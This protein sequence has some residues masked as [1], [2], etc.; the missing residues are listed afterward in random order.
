[1]S[2]HKLSAGD[3][4]TYLVRQVAA[5]DSTELGHDSLGDYYAAKGETPGRWVGTGLAGLNIGPAAIV[6]EA[7]MKALFGLGIHPDA[8]DIVKA[9]I[10]AGAE[11]AVAEAAT[12]LGASYRV[13][14]G[15]PQWR[16]RLAERYRAWNIVHGLPE[17]DRVPAAERERIR[18]DTALELFGEQH[19][20]A[21]LHDGELSGFLARQ[22][23]LESA[24]VA[25][26]DLT[27][28][29][30]KSV[31]SLWAVA[32]RAVS[33]QIEAAHD[34]AVAK[35][36]AHLEATAV[37]TR[38][39]RNGARQVDVTGLVAAQFT[40]RDSRAGDPDL[41]THVAIANKV[42]TLEG[43]WMALDARMIYRAAVTASEYYNTAL[44]AEITARIGGRFAERETAA[45]KRP[46]RELAGVDEQ[47]MRRWSTR[48]KAIEAAT[49]DLAAQFVTAHGRVPT[50]VETL[51]LAQQATLA[52]RQAKHEP[53]S[54]AEQRQVWRA[55]ALAVLGGQ[56]SLAAMLRDVHAT[57]A[58]EPVTAGLL[59]ELAAETVATVAAGRAR[60]RAANLHA[61]AIRQ[62]RA[63]G[64]DPG[65]VLEQA[66]LVAQRAMSSDHSTAIGADTDVI[67]DEQV[68][69]SLRRVDGTSQFRVAGGQLFTSPAVLAAERRILV[70]AGQAGARTLATD[71]V[72][73]AMLEWTANN[74]GRQLNPAQAQMVRDVGTTGS[75]VCLALAPAG[76][77]KTT[78][79]GVLARA[80]QASGGTVIGLA[81]QASAAEELRNALPAVDTDTVDKLVHEIKQGDPERRPEW[82]D[83]IGADSLVIV[84][85]AGLASTTNL[86]ATIDYVTGRGGRVLL[87]GDDRQRAAAG[88]GGVLR[89]IDAAYGSSSL[90][91]VMRFSDPT[92]GRATLA[93]R[94]GDP[95]AAG[96][97]TDRGRLHT[98]TSDTAVATLYS[99]W[100]SDVAA[101]RQSL[102]I[103]SSLDQVSQL[104]LLAREARLA[105][106]PPETHQG[107]E[108]TLP[109]GE[110]VSAGDTVIT[111]KNARHLSLGGSGDFVQNNHRWT[112][113]EVHPDGSLSVYLIGG[114]GRR[115][116]R[117]PASYLS[118]GHVRLGYADTLASVQGRT[119]GSAGRVDGTAHVLVDSG[120]TRN[121]LYVALSRAVT[122][123]HL[124]VQVGGGIN[125]D[126]LITPDAVHPPTAAEVFVA[127]LGRDGSARS[128]TTEIREAANP[129]AILG[130][131]AAA[132]REALVAAGEAILGPEKVTAI[133]N[134]A[135]AAV[136]GLTASPAWDTLRGHLLTIAL[137]G[138]DPVARL[139]DAAGR[140]ELDT[141]ADSGA[142]LDWRLD[143]T[144][145]HSQPAG[146]LPWLPAVPA[147]VSEHPEFS[148]YLQAWT[149]R[150]TDQAAAITA[151]AREWSPV[152]APAWA[153]PYLS[154]QDLVGT[155]ALW[156]ATAGIPDTDLRPAGPVPSRLT[157]RG[158]HRELSDACADIAGVPGEGAGRWVR[159]LAD[160]GVDVAAITSDDHW[161]VL[162]SRLNLA[163][164]ARQPVARLLEEAV[165]A[166]PLPTEAVAAALA[167]RLV[168]QLEISAQ[169]AGLD[170]QRIDPDFTDRL[171]HRGGEVHR[172][173]TDGETVAVAVLEDADRRVADLRVLQL[174]ERVISDHPAWVD[175]IVERPEQVEDELSWRRSVAAIMEYRE[176]YQV[177][178]EHSALGDPP[179]DEEQRRTYTEILRDLE[180]L[181][182]L[183]GRVETMTPVEEMEGATGSTSAV[184]HD[185]LI[186]DEIT[187]ESLAMDSA[188]VDPDGLTIDDI[189]DALEGVAA[190]RSDLARALE[191]GARRQRELDEQLSTGVGPAERKVIDAYAVLEVRAADVSQL[192]A[193]EAEVVDLRDAAVAEGVAVAGIETAIARTGRR[194]RRRLAELERA[195]AERR[196]VQARRL[197][198]LKERAGQAAA[199]QQ[200]VGPPDRQ[201]RVVEELTTAAAT[202]DERRRTAAAED[203]E[204]HAALGRSRAELAS[205]IADVE[206]QHAELLERLQ[207]LQA[208]GHVPAERE[209]QVPD[210]I[211]DEVDVASAP[212]RPIER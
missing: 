112:V 205:R 90:V 47:L 35:T 64:I 144:G 157:D 61:E 190:E 122:A 33:A 79:M 188:A 13:V 48:R 101:G 59:D 30:V 104:N 168:P 84:D 173:H 161:P 182:V 1:M 116:V 134:G 210:P 24:S 83:R 152:T 187:I 136:P 85:E 114:P 148:A 67:P 110:I 92:E 200:R 153:T 191:A 127:I 183:A 196:Q 165:H 70:V 207:Q 2:L 8:D 137:A 93:V 53:R 17:R 197:G 178:S 129:V 21:P 26:F 126:Q 194:D 44:E 147:A 49:G 145:N 16:E 181:H 139:A 107:L 28:S 98:V 43:R 138:D 176:R 80:W 130:H 124:Y 111:K 108:V 18:T 63:V 23:R 118:E 51:R 158:R 131:A 167:W 46:I 36:L 37:Y 206:R 143:H 32:D 156:R 177:T 77:G 56:S 60:W 209:A 159:V 3:G 115:Q 102:M 163:D 154:D 179:V 198:Q 105:Q 54:L 150:V 87:V 72:E 6:S 88:A 142:V 55:Q 172:T 81:P 171:I 121:E 195:L 192:R 45:G 149:S 141:A 135:R 86:D 76:T 94:D 89:D 109:N 162:V 22:S 208:A 7:Q 169:A 82:I 119:I 160:T 42:Q 203:Q 211:P 12:K 41:H 74:G 15:N 11:P 140:R 20:R 29:P 164:A 113:S 57:V 125:P 39:G 95:A 146:P 117:L 175:T 27:F 38:L 97:Y 62:V 170:E 50:A 31:S 34:A 65:Q 204:R 180:A 132:Y 40:H 5:G 120:M 185:R 69:A 189:A 166:G 73:L 128:A 91:E 52:T 99:A 201:R 75:R 58:A 199:L 71:D 25:G 184:G 151:A 193:A 123:N 66:Q 212:E 155:L 100:A 78:V 14:E 96:F 186:T 9:K 10:A 202:L 4:Y 103:A 106:L 133:V 19:G 68:P 174:S